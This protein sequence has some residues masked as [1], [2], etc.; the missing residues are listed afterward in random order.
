MAVSFLID[1]PVLLVAGRDVVY[2]WDLVRRDLGQRKLD[3]RAVP[4]HI[5]AVAEMLRDVT[6]AQTRDE[7][8]E[9]SAR[10]H[11]SRTSAD[12][13]TGLISELLSTREMAERLRVGDRQARRLAAEA[14]IEPAARNAWRARDIEALIVERN[15]R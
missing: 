6:A 14:G 11:L 1:E 2:L 15:H 13:A 5:V 4:R 7:A 3:G 10:G 9:M 12:M 8:R